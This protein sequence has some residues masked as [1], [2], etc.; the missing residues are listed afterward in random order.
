MISAFVSREYGFGMDISPDDLGR[1]NATRIGKKYSDE[2]AAIA[3]NGNSNKQQLTKNPFMTEFEY[4]VAGQ[5]YWDYNHMVLQMEDCIDVL[6]LLRGVQKYD[7]QFLYDHSSG[8]DK[9]RPD[10]LSVTRMT[11]YFGGAQARMRDTGHD[12]RGN[13]WYLPSIGCVGTTLPWRHPIDAIQIIQQ[14]TLLPV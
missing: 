5:G 6:R 13:V 10:C 14:R 2:V 4:G 7:F 8:H 12:N 1:V 11:K 3:V 9:Q